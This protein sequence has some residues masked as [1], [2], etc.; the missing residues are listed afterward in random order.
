MVKGLLGNEIPEP[1]GN[2][3]ERDSMT[4]TMPLRRHFHSPAPVLLALGA[5]LGCAA[6]GASPL[7]AQE[8][9]LIVGG[10]GQ[11]SIEVNL[12]AIDSGAMAPARSSASALLPDLRAPAVSTGPVP[13][14][15]LTPPTGAIALTPAQPIVTPVPPPPPE[16]PP[17]IETVILSSPEPAAPEAPAFE[18]DR[19]EGTAPP[20]I[21]ETPVQSVALEPPAPAPEPMPA[22]EVAPEPAPAPVV[23]QEAPTQVAALPPAVEPLGEGQVLRVTFAPEQE[24]LPGDFAGALQTLAGQLKVDEATRLQLRAYSGGTPETASQARRLSLTRALAVRSYLIGQG[25]R[26]TRIDVRALGLVEDG[27]PADRVDLFLMH[28]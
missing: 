21:D 3:N 7:A 8:E 11:P 12:H 10:S 22:P 13:T 17:V 5:A 14:I 15:S 2:Q 25:V 27:G 16:L 28:N 9:S 4:R 6:L 23:E 20:P 19:P 18:F 1:D 26:S 24:V